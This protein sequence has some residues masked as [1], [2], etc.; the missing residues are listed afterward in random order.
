MVALTPRHPAVPGRPFLPLLTG[1][2]GLTLLLTG[3]GDGQAESVQSDGDSAGA[4]D[5]CGIDVP[6]DPVP[7]RVFAAYQP[8]IEMAH[9]LGISDRLVGTAFLDAVVIEEYAE[10]QEEQEYYASL[11]SREELLNLEPDFVLTGYNDTFTDDTFGTRGSLSELGISSWIFSPL[12]PSEDGLSDATID[13]ADVTMENVYAD[14]RDLGALFGETDRAEDVIAEMEATV[15]EVTMVVADAEDEP[16]VLIARP[17]DEGFQVASG[18]DFGTEII[19]LAGGVNAA[20][21]L[22]E[23][24]NVTISTE[25]VIERDPDVILI[26]VCCDAEMTAADAA[27]DVAS[28]LDD[29]ALANVTAVKEEQVHEFTFADRAAG[30]RSAT[31]VAQVAELIHPD[32]FD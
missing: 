11:P 10:A 22:D 3:C 8:A 15:E 18:Q 30:V 2:L 17:S 20:G 23:R 16:E 1:A 19:D 5:N 24:R 29:P 4:I 25:D 28:V 9:A 26:D 21:D 27:D 14:L 32:L 6:T 12:C 7:E 31:A 13:P